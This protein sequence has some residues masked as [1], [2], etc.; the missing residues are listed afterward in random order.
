M[1][2]LVSIGVLTPLCGLLQ[3]QDD[4]I[5]LATL[6]S[7]EG[8]LKSAET[9]HTLES[10]LQI[11]REN[12]GDQWIEGMLN[13]PNATVYFKA[14]RLCQTYFGMAGEAGEEN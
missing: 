8:I 10:V 11:V 5:L 9:T 2:Y 12:A 13:H 6:C 3:I 4:T 14:E 1:D 7:V